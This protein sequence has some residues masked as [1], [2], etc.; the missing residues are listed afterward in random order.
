T[1]QVDADE[2]AVLGIH[3]VGLRDVQLAAGLLLVDGHETPATI[4]VLA[5]DA[6]RARLGVRDDANDTAAIGR[7][8]GLIRLLDTQQGAVADASGG[9]RLRPAWKGDADFWRGAALFFV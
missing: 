6:E 1:D 4:R 8:I 9:A 3:A 2:V 5:E 7:A